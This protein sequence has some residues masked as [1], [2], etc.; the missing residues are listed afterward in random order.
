MTNYLDWDVPT[1]HLSSRMIAMLDGNDLETLPPI[2]PRTNYLWCEHNKLKDLPDLPDL[3][4]LNFG[5][6]CLTKVPVL[7]KTLTSLTCDGNQIKELPELP[8][9][10]TFLTCLKNPIRILPTLPPTLKTFY[11]SEPVTIP[12]FPKT[13]NTVL[14]DSFKK[15]DDESWL[16]FIDHLPNINYR[17]IVVDA[18]LRDVSSIVVLKRML[19]SPYFNRKTVIELIVLRTMV[20]TNL[21]QLVNSDAVAVI[22]SF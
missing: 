12:N 10:L 15:L 3:T 11:V 8:D 18:M 5:Y 13:L 7:P 19:R 6:N 1:N 22:L 17:S 16:R 9:T 14:L 20:K 4:L 21:S 2:D